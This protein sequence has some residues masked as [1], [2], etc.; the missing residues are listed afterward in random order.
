MSISHLLPVTHVFVHE[1]FSPW[2]II[3]STQCTPDS[4]SYHGASFLKIESVHPKV[5]EEGFP[6]R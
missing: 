6:Q 1:T 4:H 5:A 2:L 3:G